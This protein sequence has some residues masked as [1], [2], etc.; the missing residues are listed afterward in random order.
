MME[1]LDVEV[2]VTTGAEQ[3]GPPGRR[4]ARESLDEQARR[5]GV[6]PLRSVDDLRNDDVWESDEE[7]AEFLAYL[8]AARQS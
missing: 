8:D 4:A 5:K 6:R 1:R 3:T 2:A 7:L